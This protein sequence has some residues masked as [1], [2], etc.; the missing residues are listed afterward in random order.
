MRPFASVVAVLVL[1]GAACEAAESTNS[2]APLVAPQAAL[3]PERVG[4]RRVELATLR[5]PIAASG[6]VEA[7]RIS[8]IGAEVSGRLVE[9]SVDLGDWVEAGAP[10]FRIYAAPYEAA[11]AEA[12]AEL[13]LA[14]AEY[15]NAVREERRSRTLVEQRVASQQNYEALQTRAAVSRAQVEQMRARVER[16][17]SDLERTQVK[18]PYAG[19]VVKRLAHEG[20]MPGSNPIV[21]LQESGALEAVL[22]VPESSLVPVRLG[23]PVVLFAQTSPEPIEVRVT[24]V[25]DRV[26]PDTRTYEVRASLP[27][28]ALK[29]GSYVRAEILPARH[30]PRPV[31][32][33]DAILSLDGRMYVFRLANGVVER[34]AVHLGVVGDERTEVLAGLAVGDRVAVGEHVRRLTDGSPVIPIDDAELAMPPTPPGARR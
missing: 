16:A 15:E 26:D 14:E 12:R 33:R 2:T 11:L 9:V 13:D 6:S 19:S 24:R 29:A 32:R 31:V 30:D 5:V 1:L 3:T 25:S 27:T 28:P 18:A 7:R 21:V 22:D 4:F 20:A 17:E 23:D 34:V 8:E 10:L